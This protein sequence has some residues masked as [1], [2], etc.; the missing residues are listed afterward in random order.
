MSSKEQFETDA[1]ENEYK[2]RKAG[3][4]YDA[5]RE[6]KRSKMALVGGVIVVIILGLAIFSSILFPDGP[7]AMRPGH[8]LIPPSPEYPLGTDALSRNVLS[9]IVWGARVSLSVGLGACAI[10]LVIGVSIGLVSGYFGGWID[11]VF[12]RLADTLLTLPIILLL[13]VANSMFE[14]RSYT[15]IIVLMG[16]MGWP[17][18][19]RVVRSET[20]TVKNSL[21][22]TAAKSMGAGEFR[23]LFNHILTNLLPS[24][25]TLLTLDLPS[26]ILWESTISF[27]GLGD[28]NA[29][30]WGLML[31]FGKTY[32]RRAWW[33]TTFPGIMIFLTTLGFN[34]LGNGLRDAL[35][36]RARQ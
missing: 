24:I 20:L 25:I 16:L 32:L 2:P 7:H 30:T 10:E 34:L 3:A 27:L 21:F 1:S 31:N 17:W 22:V 33:V 35:D 14:L 5:W 15:L 6:F 19:A 8:N 23:I 13:I 26:Y 36:V 28:P 11:D 4:I 18:M 9:W 12:M 29:A